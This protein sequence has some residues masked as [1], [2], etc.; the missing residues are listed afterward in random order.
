MREYHYTLIVL[1]GFIV[2]FY[3]T[4]VKIDTDIGCDCGEQ[5]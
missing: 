4:M 5:L 3:A 1:L 2:F